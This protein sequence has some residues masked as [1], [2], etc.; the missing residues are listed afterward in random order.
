MV[1]SLSPL[2]CLSLSFNLSC[3]LCIL[4]LSPARSLF[5]SHK[6]TGALSH[7]HLYFKRLPSLSSSFLTQPYLFIFNNKFH[8]FS[9]LLPYRVELSL[10]KNSWHE[11][12]E[13]GGSLKADV[14]RF[15]RKQLSM[16]CSYC[17]TNASSLQKNRGLHSNQSHLNTFF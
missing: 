9:S 5:L 13:K 4:S 14:V 10:G 12:L 3:S 1:L 15:S 8:S 16:A 17:D 6:I 2:L 7:T 11:K